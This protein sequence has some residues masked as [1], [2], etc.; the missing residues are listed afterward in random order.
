L[1][2]PLTYFHGSIFIIHGL[3]GGIHK[4]FLHPDTRNV[5]FHHVLPDHVFNPDNSTNARIWVYGY[6]AQYAFEMAANR[7][8][9]DFAV[10]LLEAVRNV[11]VAGRGIIWISHSLGGIVAKT[12][13]LPSYG[14][15]TA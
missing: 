11:H 4:S 3:N 2:W 14:I 8:A 13:S 5:W 12:V 15:S 1:T 10:E 6:A 7:G 9:Y